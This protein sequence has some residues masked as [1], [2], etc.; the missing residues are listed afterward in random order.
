MYVLKSARNSAVGP[1]GRPYSMYQACTLFTAVLLQVFIIGLLDG[2]LMLEPSIVCA[3]LVFIPKKVFSISDTG[4][5][6]YRSRDVRPISL[7]NTFTKFIAACLKLTLGRIVNTLVHKSQKCIP[8]RNLLDNVI[9]LDAAMHVLSVSHIN[10]SIAIFFDFRAAFPSV[11][12]AYIW[13]VLLALGLPVAFISAVKQLYAN[14]IH[15]IKMDGKLFDGPTLLAGVRQ[16]CPLSMIIFALCLEPL[17][18]KLANIL[19]EG[20]ALGAFADDIG[21]VIHNPWDKINRMSDLFD[22]FS[23]CSHLRLKFDKCVIVNLGNDEP[24]PQVISSLLSAA[25]NWRSFL[26]RDRA[27]YLRFQLGPGGVDKQ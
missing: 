12:H 13:K 19:E 8:G 15:W 23:K 5:K 10:N 26:V 22:K 2:S 20:D 7:S 3:F 9:A 25:P 16:G 11:A 17:L 4:I 18:R 27:E 21:I 1:D 6:V 14:N 24:Q